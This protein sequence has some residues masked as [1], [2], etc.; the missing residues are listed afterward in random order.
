MK[1]ARDGKL[2]HESEICDTLNAMF[3]KGDIVE[4]RMM[5]RNSTVAGYYDHDH[6]E[7]CARHVSMYDE[8]RDNT[9]VYYT[10]NPVKPELHSRSHNKLKER[11][12]HTA[13][14]KD[15]EKRRLLPIDIDPVRPPDTSSTDALHELCIARAFEIKEWLI[16]KGFCD[17]IVADSGNGAHVDVFID[18]PN[19]PESLDLV[20]TVQKVIIQKFNQPEK[21]KVDIQGFANAARIWKLYGT[22]TRKGDEVPDMGIYHRRSKILYR[23]E[24]KEITTTAQL[25]AV[26]DMYTSELDNAQGAGYKPDTAKHTGGKFNLMEFM[27]KHNIRI[28][29]TIPQPDKHRT[30]HRLEECPFNPDHKGKDSAIFQF[31]DGRLGFDCK[32]HSCESKHWSDV[33]ELFEPGYKDKR[34]KPNALPEVP[35]SDTSNAPVHIADVFRLLKD[36]DITVSRSAKQDE[37]KIYTFKFGGESFQISLAQL[38]QGPGRFRTMYANVS[39]DIVT[40]N[41][42]EWFTYVKWIMVAADDV[43]IVETAATMAADLLLEKMCNDMNFSDDKNKLKERENCTHMVPHNPH[44]DLEYY[45]VPSSAIAIMLSEIPIST[46]LPDVSV[47]MT[48]KGYKLAK[49][50]PVKLP[51]TTTIRCWWFFADIV[52]KNWS[53]QNVEN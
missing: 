46:K 2:A 16:S 49:T 14:D 45:V 53:E 22:Q 26:A 13:G 7:A 6:F 5:R 44:G 19:T 20:K 31:D 11:Q 52:D 37:T 47:A 34:N 40:I 25:Q 3:D 15:I 43:G 10:C 27:N 23:P 9:A 36:G 1:M 48:I 50:F 51:D 38:I 28:Q 18:E 30:M 42:N 24:T 12:K 29:T 41:K 39:K 33:R 21:D 17:A 32:H 35:V 8:K 4:I